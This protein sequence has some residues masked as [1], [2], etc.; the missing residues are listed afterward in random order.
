MKKLAIVFLLLACVSLVPAQKTRWKPQP[1]VRP[2]ITYPI[3][4]HISDIHV[5]QN[6][7][8]KWD[9][10]ECYAELTVDAVI[11]QKKLELSGN[12]TEGF[13]GNQLPQVHLVPGDYN[14]RLMKKGQD[15]ESALLFDEYEI[16]LPDHTTWRGTV[17]GISE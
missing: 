9:C 1:K 8:G 14:A 16:L 10:N 6:H 13:L 4:V 15:T 3:K 5:M 17:T 2:V 7:L 12:F 11:D